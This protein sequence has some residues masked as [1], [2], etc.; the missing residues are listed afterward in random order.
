MEVEANQFRSVV[1]N[2]LGGRPVFGRHE[3]VGQF[4]RLHSAAVGQETLENASASR[5]RGRIVVVGRLRRRAAVRL[6]SVF[7]EF[8][9]GAASP[10]HY[11]ERE[12]LD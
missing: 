8:G 12:G 6:R 2:L 10:L 3:F 11:N 7:E 4:G 9:I 1:R 5:L